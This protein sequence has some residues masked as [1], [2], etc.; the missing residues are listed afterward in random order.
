MLKVADLRVIASSKNDVNMKQYL[1]GLGILTIRDREIQGIKNLVAN[2]TD[3]TINLCYFYIGYRVPKIS[4]EFDLLVFNQQYDVINIELKSNI[5][6]AK[7]KIK[8][9]LVSNKYYLSTITRSVKSVTYN[10]DLNTF[11]TLT[12]KNELIKVS[13][14]DVNAMLVAFNSVD[15]GDLDNLFKPE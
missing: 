4:K 10:S 9:Q 13:I 5:N 6:Y 1:N 14:T 7:E 3:P 12:D 15:I 11:Y 8:K 2:F